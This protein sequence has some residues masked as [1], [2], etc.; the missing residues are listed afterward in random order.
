MIEILTLHCFDLQHW[1]LRSVV[2]IE[3]VFGGY[4]GHPDSADC[5]RMNTSTWSELRDY[6]GVGDTESGG[7]LGPGKI[8]GLTSVVV[9]PII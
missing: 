4:I 2:T 5:A 7:A 6:L 1:S 9:R 3:E 8:T